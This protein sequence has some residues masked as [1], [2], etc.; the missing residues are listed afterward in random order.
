MVKKKFK[1]GD[2][3]IDNMF[4]G[5]GIGIVRKVLKTRIKVEFGINDLVTY[6]NAH[7]QF[8]TKV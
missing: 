8:L 1:K 5:K 2:L 3:V 4:Y 7:L 6:D